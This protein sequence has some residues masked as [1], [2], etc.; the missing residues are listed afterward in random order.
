MCVF[1]L[2]CLLLWL[3]SASPLRS[4]PPITAEQLQAALEPLAKAHAGTV[5]ISVQVLD[6]EGRSTLRWQRNGDQVLP[7]ASLIKVP[8]MMEVYRQAA[9]GKIDLQE[10]LT[11][12]A[13]DQV[14]GSGI[15]TE[16]F[17]AGAQLP[18][19][20]AVRLMIRYSDNTA[21]NLLV[22]RLGIGAT[23]ETMAEWGFPETQLHSLVFRRDTSIAPQRSE[24]YG[25]GSTTANDMCEL[26]AR[27]ER[28]EIVSP[29]ASQEMLDH[30][31][32]CDDTAKLPRELPASCRIAHKTGSVNRTR[33]AAGI[34]SGNGVKFAICVLT[35]DNQDTSWVDDNAA[36]ILIGGL[37][38]KVYDLLLDATSTSQTAEQTAAATQPD[39]SAGQPLRIGATGELVESLQR[40]LNARDKAGLS[41]DGDFGPATQAAVRQFQQ[42]HQLAASGVVDNA[43]W[44]ALGPLVEH[45]PAVPAPEEIN[46][47]RLPLAERLDPHAPPQVSARAWAILDI[48]SEQWIGSQAADEQLPMASTT[49]IMTALLVL[50]LAAKDPHVLD[51][52]VTFSQRADRT[53]GSTAG[54]RAGEQLPV[55][56][57]LYGLLLPSGNDAAVALAEHFG[58]R[59]GGRIEGDSDGAVNNSAGQA[60]HGA[61]AAYDLFV[62]AMNARARELGLQHTHFTNPHG[63]TDPAH[64]SSVSDLAR[65]ARAAL[66]LPVMGEIVGCRQRGATLRSQEG[67]SRNVLWEN[68]NRLLAQSGFSG[69]KTGTTDAAGAC[70]VALGARPLAQ[71]ESEGDHSDTPPTTIVVVL[72]CS[73][74][75]ARYIDARNLFAWAW[76]H[77]ERQPER[78]AA[79]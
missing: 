77:A 78:Q 25:L 52:T 70:L 69:M 33:T 6:A 57:L 22:E 56:E 48:D 30:L 47:V 46:L 31:L 41:V 19:R 15:L 20:D 27:L 29:A 23:A 71:S 26:F 79:Q 58:E 9:A 1:L 13:E 14:P 21:T 11:L 59:I 42:R 3:S 8:V 24:K 60:R 36:H 37:A 65:L 73:S 53:P 7:T 68:T 40:T 49:K 16:H 61:L 10:L 66:R 17:S 28:G 55:K 43:T 72:G 67:Y 50:E 5:A 54:V 44:Q 32:T 39:E 75:D 62:A 38:R 4:A 35:D 51:E 63:L 64:H 74:S 12:R 76:R 18:I 2:G 45:E 34:I